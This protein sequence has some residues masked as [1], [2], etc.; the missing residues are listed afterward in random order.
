MPTPYIDAQLREMYSNIKMRDPVHV[1]YETR[2]S[3]GTGGW[4]LIFDI[5][6]GV[7]EFI[8]PEPHTITY[9][10]WVAF[11]Q[12]ERPEMNF[13]NQG[14]DAGT[15]RH[16]AGEF[17][18]I[19]A[20]DS[21]GIVR[22]TT[23]VTSAEI[24]EQLQATLKA[25]KEEGCLFGGEGLDTACEDVGAEDPTA[26]PASLPSALQ[27]APIVEK[28][29]GRGGIASSTTSKQMTS[30]WLKLLR[31]PQAPRTPNVTYSR[32]VEIEE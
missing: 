22:P 19:S 24:V 13:L 30:R 1:S 15:I 26:L 11:A 9:E 10:E 17:I 25:A 20:P 21:K 23:K 31:A 18:F 12:G 29:F 2:G 3:V 8:V 6:S 4:F 16:S 5:Y 14:C 32:F 7:F 27:A 28:L